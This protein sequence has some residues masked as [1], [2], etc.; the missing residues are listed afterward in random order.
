MGSGVGLG[1]GLGPA[2]REREACCVAC[3][4]LPCLGLGGS[5]I[6][7]GLHQRHQIEHQ[8]VLFGRRLRV[9]ELEQLLE[10]A[11]LV[12][13]RVRVRGRIRGRGRGRGRGRLR[14]RV[15]AA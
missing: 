6:L 14:V 3:L 2:Y 1:L 5:S 9:L 15:R 13:V 12:R 7:E 4:M 10:A 8:L 11:H